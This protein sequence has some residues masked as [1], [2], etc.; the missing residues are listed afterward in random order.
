MI[1]KPIK[2]DI[3]RAATISLVELLDKYLPIMDEDNI[4]VITS[5]I[6][7]ICENRL[8]SKDGIEKQDIVRQEATYY[9][10][11]ELSKYGYHFTITNNTLIA[12]AGIDESNGD[13]NYILWPQNVQKTV[14]YIRNYLIKRFKLNHVGVIITDSTCTPL[15]R[16]TIGIALGHS[17]FRAINNYVGEPD[18]FDRPF[19][20]SKSNV[21]G[22][23]AASAVVV[24]GEGTECTP[25]VLI[26]DI[27]FVK[28]QKR[29][30]S[31]AELQELHIPKKDDL[32]APF[33]EKTDWLDG[34]KR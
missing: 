24:M 31:V 28:F 17:G 1:I 15:R 20:V 9:L 4:L 25:L 13:G 5:K 34:E 12:C 30:P 33:L 11:G 16:G 29:N 8:I 32:F 22:G 10:P 21:S 6:V 19:E 2:T 14:N 26:S 23:L 27:P 3:I 18:L 7:S